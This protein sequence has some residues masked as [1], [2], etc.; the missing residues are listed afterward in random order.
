LGQ[1]AMTDKQRVFSKLLNVHDSLYNA[2][3]SLEDIIPA[4]WQKADLAAVLEQLDSMNK[5]LEFIMENEWW[6]A[7]DVYEK[8]FTAGTLSAQKKSQEADY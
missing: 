1:K 6:K 2:I 3:E 7:A 8:G 4:G 5:Q